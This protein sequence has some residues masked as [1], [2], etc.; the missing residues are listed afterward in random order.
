MPTSLCQ[1]GVHIIFG[2]KRHRPFLSDDIHAYIHGIISKLNGVP[3]CING[4]DNH[5]HIIAF[6]PKDMCVSDFVRAIKASSSKWFK[7]K[8]P[9]M[10]WQTGY[11]AFGVSKTNIPRVELY[12]KSQKE[13]HRSMDF[14]EEM[15]K[16]LVEIGGKDVYREWFDYTDRA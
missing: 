16:Y 11:A 4:T 14:A 13:H 6:M 5:I 7:T 8:N 12:I 10:E 9:H 3:I 15:K 1:I 2:T